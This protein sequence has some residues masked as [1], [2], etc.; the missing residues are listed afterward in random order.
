MLCGRVTAASSSQAGGQSQTISYGRL[1]KSDRKG[2]KDDAMNATSRKDTK[3][4]SPVPRCST[5]LRNK[6]ARSHMI[7]LY[8]SMSI[9]TASSQVQRLDKP[10]VSH[11]R[12]LGTDE[13]FPLT[14][15]D[16]P[17]REAQGGTHFVHPCGTELGHASSLG[18]LWFSV[19]RRHKPRGTQGCTGEPGLN[20][21]FPSRC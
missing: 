8:T 2:R 7:V 11:P 3:G 6:S 19:G 18:K 21:S 16:T 10:Q 9:S 12:K 15:F 4:T 14:K 5:V 1:T 20:Q 17:Q 13:R